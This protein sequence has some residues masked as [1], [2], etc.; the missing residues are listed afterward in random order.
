MRAVCG[1]VMA[2]AAPVVFEPSFGAALEMLPPV[3]AVVFE[4]S[5][6]TRRSSASR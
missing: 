1:I 3:A 4:P 2:S 5:Y 6:R